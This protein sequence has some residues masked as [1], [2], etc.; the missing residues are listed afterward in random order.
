MSERTDSRAF[1]P[2]EPDKIFDIP[3]EDI[4]GDMDAFWEPLS[5]V[6]SPN[7]Q[8]L[9][10]LMRSGWEPARAEDFPRQSGYGHQLPGNLVSRGFLTEVQADDPIV[11]REMMLLIRPKALSQRARQKQNAEARHI[12]DNQMDRL[13][14][15][16]TS[17][18]GGMRR[19]I[20]PQPDQAEMAAQEM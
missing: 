3:A 20:A 8:Q 1:T 19:S 15:Q 9:S 11:Q 10:E 5:I 16:Y 6:G 18:R 12:V 17:H 2:P 7:K 4:P 14:A 13:R